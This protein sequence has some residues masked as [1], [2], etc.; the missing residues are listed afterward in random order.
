MSTPQER[1]AVVAEMRAWSQARDRRAADL[2][3]QPGSG[4]TSVF[5]RVAY[6]DHEVERVEAFWDRADRRWR[7]LAAACGEFPEPLQASELAAADAEREQAAAECARLR[8]V[9]DACMAEF[10][11]F[12]SELWHP[13][14]W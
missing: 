3:H 10:E 1:A 14:V 8:S 4:A 7:N 11:Q 13:P 5:D 2:A 12:R 9:R 6:W